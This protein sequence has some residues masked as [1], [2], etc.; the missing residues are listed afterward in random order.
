MPPP[1][2]LRPQTQ[3]ACVSSRAGSSE[4]PAGARDG[5]GPDSL[6]SS[7]LSAWQVVRD[8][9]GPQTPAPSK[10]ICIRAAGTLPLVFAWLAGARGPCP[11]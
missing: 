8:H 6:T 9:R 4:P 3:P 2:P 11:Q 7:C 1:T 5:E 10:D